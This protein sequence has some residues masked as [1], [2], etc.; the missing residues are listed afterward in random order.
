ML[1]RRSLLIPERFEDKNYSK[2]DALNKLPMF[3]K[4]SSKAITDSCY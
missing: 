1:L 2:Y 3:F 4:R